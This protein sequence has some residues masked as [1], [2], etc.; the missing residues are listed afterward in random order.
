MGGRRSSR[1]I[2]K[3]N[4]I[5]RNIIFITML[6]IGTFVQAQK[7]YITKAGSMTFEA[8]VP[9]FEEVKAKNTSTTAILNID[10]G[11][12]AALALIRG[13]RF[14]NALMEEHFNENYA[15]SNTYPK[16]TFR[17]TIRDYS[18]ESISIKDD[19]LIDGMLEFHGVKRNL[20]DV[21]IILSKTE[22]SIIIKGSFSVLATDFN[23]E[24]PKIVS[25]KL[26]NEVNVSFEFE[27]FKK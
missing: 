3:I 10:N 26:S 20:N 27:L 7:K 4:L 12:F 23:I 15:E 14:K 1:R 18:L 25:N 21:K 24:I 22:N 9:S 5:M 2:I 16:A 11:E 17:G 19:F 13:F 6:C 8:S